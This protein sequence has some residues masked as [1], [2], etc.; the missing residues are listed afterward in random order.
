[1]WED[2]SFREIAELLSAPLQTIAS[3]YRYALE[4]LRQHQ[5]ALER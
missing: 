3:R 4:K 2:L 5:P 1:V